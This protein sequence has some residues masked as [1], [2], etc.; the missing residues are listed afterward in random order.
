MHSWGKLWTTR[1]KKTKKTKKQKSQLPLSE[2]QEQ[3][4]GVEGKTRGLSMHPAL[5]TSKG[6][7]KTPKPPLHQPLDIPLLSPQIKSQLT[8]LPRGAGSGQGALS[9]VFSPC[10]VAGAS[11]KPHLSFLVSFSLSFFTFI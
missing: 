2:S 6:V 3:K 5:I 8:R 11:I 1:Y 10:C 9:L 4:Q 7:G